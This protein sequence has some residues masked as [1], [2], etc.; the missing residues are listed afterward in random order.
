MITKAPVVWLPLALAACPAEANPEIGE[1]PADT[2]TGTAPGPTTTIDTGTS[3]KPSDATG[4]WSGICGADIELSSTLQLR[5]ESELALTEDQGAI[6]GTWDF[7]EHYVYGTDSGT[8]STGEALLEGSRS[9]DE[10]VLTST[11]AQTGLG[12][13]IN[14]TVQFDLLQDG[15]S[16]EGTL[17]ILLDTTTTTVLSNLFCELG[18]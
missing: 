2:D 11:E 4:V 1:V 5:L 3:S 12:H 7:V 13:P 14:G 8:L 16:L 10:I 6:G 18:R 9:G 17:S 15:D